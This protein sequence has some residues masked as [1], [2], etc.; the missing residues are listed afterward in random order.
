MKRILIFLCVLCLLLPFCGCKKPETPPP[1][2]TALP[3][4]GEVEIAVLALGKADAIVI[5]TAT[6]TVVID[7]GEIDDGGKVLNYLNE[8]GRSAIDCLIVTHYD[9]DHV[10][11]ADRLLNFA[12]VKQVIRPDYNGVRDEYSTFLDSVNGLEIPDTALAAGGEDITI[13]VEDLHLTINSPLKS[14]YVNEEGV[15]QDNNF[16]LVIKAQHG[17]KTFLFAGD[18]EDERLAELITSNTNWQADFLKIPYHGN[19]TELSTGFFQRVKPA[20]A[21]ACDSDKNPMADETKAALTLL[22]CKCYGTMNGTVVCKSD[23]ATLT[24]TQLPKE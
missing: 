19:F 1:A 14:S 7:A 24:V 22:G 8:K 4:T 13:T 21:V 11:G 3:V 23:G 15:Q 18:A 10:G 16:S 12:D 6:K 17:A 20:Y 5:T 9:R 2:I